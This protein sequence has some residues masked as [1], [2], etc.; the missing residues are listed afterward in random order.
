MLGHR[1]GGTSAVHRRYILAIDDRRA[2]IQARRVD[3]TLRVLTTR[4]L[5]VSM[6]G[7]GLL[8]IIEADSI[9]DEWAARHRFRLK[10]QSFRDFYPWRGFAS[11]RRGVW[12]APRDAARKTWLNC[13]DDEPSRSLEAPPNSSCTSGPADDDSQ[14]SRAEDPRG[15]PFSLQPTCFYRDVR[16]V[17]GPAA[18]CDP[19]NP[20]VPREFFSGQAP[21]RTERWKSRR[22]R[23]GSV[24]IQTPAGRCRCRSARQFLLRR[25]P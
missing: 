19:C 7:E 1:R 12:C 20:L 22:K 21:P 24:P 16:R 23:P 3:Q 10:L 8:D 25:L 4:D 13:K 14:P 9:K 2:T 17:T 11:D 15:G 5:M 6:I 18:R